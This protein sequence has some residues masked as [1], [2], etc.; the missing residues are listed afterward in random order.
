[1]RY[2]R[3]IKHSEHHPWDIKTFHIGK[4]YLLKYDDNL[5]LLFDIE[6]GNGV[7]AVYHWQIVDVIYDNR[8]NRVLYPELKPNGEGFLI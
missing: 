8:L 6:T 2:V 3:Y 7:G 4:I 5:P 1:M